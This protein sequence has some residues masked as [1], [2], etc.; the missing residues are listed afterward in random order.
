VLAQHARGPDY[1]VPST[2]K[3]KKRKKK[4]NNTTC[5]LSYAGCRLKFKRA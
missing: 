2:A 5:F 4:K 1:S 3:I